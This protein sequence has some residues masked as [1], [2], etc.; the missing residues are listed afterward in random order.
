M[1]T[2][3]EQLEESGLLLR[4][5]LSLASFYFTRGEPL[6]ALATGRR[7]LELAEHA[8]DGAALAYAAYWVACGAHASGQL[9]EA[10]SR[11][12][13]SMLHAELAN[14]RDLILPIMVWSA[15]AIQCSN[16]LASMGRVTEAAKLAEDGLRYA[17]ES[18]HLFSLGLALSVKPRT[19]CFLLE[20]EIV[21]AH[22]EEEIALS[23]EHGFAEW[24]PWGRF[25]RG[26]ALA[27]LGRVEEG[28]GEICSKKRWSTSTAAE[29]STARRRCC[30][31]RARSC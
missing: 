25:H 31:S 12:A 5:L 1:C 13:E 14:Q 11:Y 10:A 18:R 6:R 7:C 16:V 17:R 22:A 30:G 28:V 26:W 20:P 15:S 29:S 8:S 9:G 19:H 2:L 4:G 21:R 23:E 3:A 24:I 27:A